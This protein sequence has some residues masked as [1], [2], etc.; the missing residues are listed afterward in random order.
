MQNIF[1]SIFFKI[2][3]NNTKKIVIENRLFLKE[4]GEVIDSKTY[5]QNNYGIQNRIF[6]KI[7]LPMTNNLI[8]SDLIIFILNNCIK[9]NVKY[10][11]IGVSAL[12]NFLLINNSLNKS[13]LVSYDINEI[14]PLHSERLLNSKKNKITYFKG[15]VLDK[16]DLLKFKEQIDLKF[17]FIFSD[18]LH[19]PE[20]LKNEYFNIYKDKLDDQ[21]FIYFDDLDFPNL[22]NAAEDIYNDMNKN[23]DKLNFYTF[24][25][26]G[27][28]G[29]YEPLHLNGIITNI[30]FE[31]FLEQNSM[32]IPFFK[33]IN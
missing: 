5:S 8:Y 1:V 14:N 32:K 33:K 15:S 12:K 4:I 23:H 21:F 28:I 6:K 26:F 3:S 2:S 27:W 18:A 9:K 31:K 19:T 7:N 16:T 11:E 17:N 29:H 25:L 30:D 24:K 13:D 20:G 22:F 10:L